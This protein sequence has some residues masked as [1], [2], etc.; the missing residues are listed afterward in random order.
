MVDTILLFPRQCPVQAPPN[1]EATVY[2]PF[3]ALKQVCCAAQ[4]KR[5]L[6]ADAIRK[7]DVG[8]VRNNRRRGR[9]HERQ[10]AQ[11]VWLDEVVARSESDNVSAA[12]LNGNGCRLVEASTVDAHDDP[13]VREHVVRAFK[14]ANIF[15]SDAVVSLLRGR[16][17][18][19]LQRRTWSWP[20]R[21]SGGNGGVDQLQSERVNPT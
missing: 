5:I 18:R 15:V 4:H 11:V 2:T 17:R 14:V 3:T 19:G 16:E 21:W 13:G 20:W 7:H 1:R 6:V 10:R 8:K 9:V 12:V